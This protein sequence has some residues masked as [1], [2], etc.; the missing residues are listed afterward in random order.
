[1]SF[2]YVEPEESL[3][4]K[5]MIEQVTTLRAMDLAGDAVRIAELLRTGCPGIGTL[6][7]QELNA[8]LNSL[9]NTV[10]TV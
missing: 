8:E 9:W 10:G 1:M 7:D 2:E 5:A 6:S 4:R 3:E